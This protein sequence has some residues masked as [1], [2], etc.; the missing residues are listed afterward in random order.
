MVCLLR[1]DL[2]TFNTH[3]HTTSGKFDMQATVYLDTKITYFP[4]KWRKEAAS[5]QGP[6]VVLI[7]MEK[8]W[9]IYYSLRTH[10]ISAPVKLYGRLESGASDCARSSVGS[11]DRTVLIPKVEFTGS[12]NVWQRAQTPLERLDVEQQPFDTLPALFHIFNEK[13]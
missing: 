13:L 2:Q 12:R 5:I 3:L 4:K 9:I 6:W 10:Q 7:N 1:R 8:T 11:F